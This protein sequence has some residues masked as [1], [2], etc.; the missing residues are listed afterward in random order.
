[1]DLRPLTIKMKS[2]LKIR[3]GH[4]ILVFIIAFFGKKLL[5]ADGSFIGGIDVANYF[6]WHAQFIKEQLLSGSIPLWNPYYYSGHPFI[7]NP[8]TFVFYPTTLL[9]L[10]LPL[11]W[12][13]NLD[14]ILHIY[15]AATGTY[16][17]VFLVSQSRS[18]GLAAAIVYSLS[19]YFINNIFAG[20]LTMIHTAA[21]MPWIFYFIEKFFK[22]RRVI[23]LIISGFIFG[24]QILSG[25]PQNNYYTGLFF[26]LFFYIR[27][28]TTQESVLSKQFI[29]TG[30]YYILIPAIA[31]GI[32]AIQIL[33]SLE[34]MSLCDRAEK[35]YAFATSYSFPPQC[36]FTFLV[37]K[38][39]TSNAVIWEELKS[40]SELVLHWELN[41]YLGILSIILA[42]IGGTFPKHRRYNKC[43]GI[44]L[45]VAVTI[46][47]G[48]YTSIYKLY[49]LLLPG[50]STFRIPARCIVILV[51]FM[52]VLVGFGVQRL[53]E[54][55]LT[56]KQHCIAM[57][58][59][60]IL[61]LCLLGGAKVFQIPLS[62]KEMLVAIGL[63]ISSMCILNLIRFLK[64][65]HIGIGL[66]LIVLFVDLYLTH[67][68]Q[69]PIQYPSRLLQKREYEIVFQ[70]DPGFYRV[71]LP[72]ADVVST[73]PSRGMK[74][75]Y[76]GINGYTPI[77]L[78]SYF[79]FVHNMANLT[80]PTILRHTLDLQLFQP[81]LMFSSK[82]LGIKYAMAKTSELGYKM[83]TTQKVMPR[84]VL[85]REALILPDLE[86]HIEYIKRD[87][88]NPEQTVLLESSLEGHNLPVLKQ[89]RKSTRNDIVS[90]KQYEP[91]RIVLSSVSDSN[92]Y[93]VLSELF[94]PGW[95]AYVDG[96]EV[97]ILRANYLLRAIP[98]KSGEHNI[99]FVYR[100]MSFLLGATI[101]T[102]TLLFLGGFY[103]ISIRK[104]GAPN[105]KECSFQIIFIN[106]PTMQYSA[107][108][109]F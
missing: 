103:L 101:S 5:T 56:G 102:L 80:K 26:T 104:K 54:S 93:L 14:T 87:G 61:F 44:M 109:S 96:K 16:F 73:F 55:P 57:I 74:F 94:Y 37:P 42:G 29:R 45:L 70:K 7:A 91:N 20:H 25:E 9:F 13:F 89:D 48:H 83:L 78:N 10:A 27:L 60:I 36:L 34:F 50:I 79:K 84:A 39:S 46:M 71:N 90:I 92:T 95:H 72:D 66:L 6:F 32:S 35:T 82:I 38:P 63:A 28:F 62:S 8:Q 51:L 68:S 105:K 69:I 12:A 23:F 81:D 67:S 24:L 40:Y 11:P 2:V 88:F 77:V 98:L 15:L 49:Y 17:F 75:H 108:L 100:P 47:I 30:I 41:G 58:G 106:V 22:T 107:T 33:P 43:F 31:F 99:E 53:R 97:S 86:E 3:P 76:Y 52:S 19:G 64:N 1:M 21:L 59:F 85:V 4:I 65:K 18:A